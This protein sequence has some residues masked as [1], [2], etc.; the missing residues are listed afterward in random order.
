LARV[1]TDGS[2]D[3]ESQRHW[4]RDSLEN[5]LIHDASV[6]ATSFVI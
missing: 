6:V 4:E 2:I 1:L 5:M 3:I